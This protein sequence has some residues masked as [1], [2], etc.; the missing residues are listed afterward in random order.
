MDLE[1]EFTYTAMLKPPVEIGPGPLGTRMFFEAIDGPV[2]GERLRGTVLTGGG[3]WAL[4][5]PDGFVRL[6]VRAQMRTDDGA[7][8]YLRY[9]GLLE[10]NDAVQ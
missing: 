4:L 5:G 2:T 3:D 10:F 8:V 1:H 6:D 9:D 7:A